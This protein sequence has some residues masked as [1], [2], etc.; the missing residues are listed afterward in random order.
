[1]HNLHSSP[2]LLDVMHGQLLLILLSTRFYSMMY[3]GHCM[4]VTQCLIMVLCLAHTF[5]MAIRAAYL[6]VGAVEGR[7]FLHLSAMPCVLTMLCTLVCFHG[8]PRP[9]PPQ[10]TGEITEKVRKLQFS[11]NF[12]TFS[13]VIF[14]FWGRLVGG[15][16]FA[17][18]R[19]L[20]GFS[21]WGS[22]A[23]CKGMRLSQL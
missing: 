5:G 14:L 11:C 8:I 2:W 22:F 1:M 16:E 10:K 4:I 21:V 17:F 7:A 18:S 3:R 12:R 19:Q 23:P 20:W 6:F 15:G 13:S 9:P